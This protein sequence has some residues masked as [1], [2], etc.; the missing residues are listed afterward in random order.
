MKRFPVFFGAILLLIL[1]LSMPQQTALA[2]SVYEDYTFT[3]FAGPSDWV[4]ESLDGLGVNA[5]FSGPADVVMDSN[6][7][8][9]IAD[10][11][12]NTIRK[13]APDGQVTTLA[14]LAGTSGTNDGL[15][16]A[17]RFFGPNSLAVDPQGNVYV[18]D[19]GNDT[20]RKITPAGL[21]TTLA[22]MPGV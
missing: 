22:G 21:V 17:A 13:M 9:Y 12:N 4:A 16:A 18:A 15:G 6:G 11:S 2:G 14:G 20:I 19:T 10:R 3:T 8:F 7:N 5:R 1:G